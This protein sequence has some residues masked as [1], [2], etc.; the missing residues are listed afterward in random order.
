MLRTGKEVYV[1]EYVRKRG[2]E[3]IGKE[4]IMVLDPGFKLGKDNGN[5]R[6]KDM[7]KL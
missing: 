3:G 1:M 5:M 6:S 2:I 7:E 4:M